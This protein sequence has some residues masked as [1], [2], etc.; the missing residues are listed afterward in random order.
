M[1]CFIFFAISFM[2]SFWGK[3]FLLF[4]PFYFFPLNRDTLL[5]PSPGLLICLEALCTGVSRAHS[6]AVPSPPMTRL[7]LA[8]PMLKP[9]SNFFSLFQYW[10]GSRAE[11]PISSSAPRGGGD[12]GPPCALASRR[13][14]PIYIAVHTYT[15]SS[16][17]TSL[18]FYG[19]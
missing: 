4:P 15:W 2:F 14:G 16:G 9:V 7:L 17:H 19:C 12:G 3:L 6:S 13:W 5:A 18:K 1:Y 11:R 10:P 8:T